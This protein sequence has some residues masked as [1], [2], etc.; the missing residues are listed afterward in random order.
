MAHATRFAYL[1]CVLQG[2]EE[3]FVLKLLF[4]NSHLVLFKLIPGK[5][6]NYKFERYN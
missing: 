1:K 4:T 2:R 6:R 3:D 5:A